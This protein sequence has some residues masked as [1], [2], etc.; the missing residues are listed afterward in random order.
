MAMVNFEVYFEEKAG[1]SV[2]QRM[3]GPSTKGKGIHRDTQNEFQV[4]ELYDELDAHSPQL[5]PQSG[6]LWHMLSAQ[7]SLYQCA[8]K[9]SS[10]Q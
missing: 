3:G 5:L 4:L 6:Q 8:V 9:A 1:H 7:K 10:D 2:I